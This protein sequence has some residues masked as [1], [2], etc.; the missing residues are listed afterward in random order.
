MHYINKL[1]IEIWA[2][3][4]AMQGGGL[5]AISF[6]FFITFIIE[7]KTKKDAASIPHA[8]PIV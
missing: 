4:Q 8:K 5:Y 6:S 2:C 1:I 3:P 7:G